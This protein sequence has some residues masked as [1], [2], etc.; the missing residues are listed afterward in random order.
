MGQEQEKKE[1]RTVTK[2]TKR[3][4]KKEKKHDAQSSVHTIASL[5]PLLSIYSAIYL[6]HTHQK[7]S[8]TCKA[9][10][11]FPLLYFTLPTYS[12]YLHIVPTLAPIPRT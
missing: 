4:K 6:L 7:K 10:Y 12:H 2:T 5:L 9:I 1:S 8:I 11:T 3:R